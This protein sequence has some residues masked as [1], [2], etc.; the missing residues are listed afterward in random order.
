MVGEGVFSGRLQ[1]HELQSIR[2]LGQRPDCSALGT[3]KESFLFLGFHSS[4]L[5]VSLHLSSP[6]WKRHR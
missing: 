5:S 4:A 1:S 3:Y 6:L 2:A